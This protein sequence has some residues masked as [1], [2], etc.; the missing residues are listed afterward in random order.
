[1]VDVLAP[2]SSGYTQCEH[3]PRAAASFQLKL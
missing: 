1:M 2:K 3:V